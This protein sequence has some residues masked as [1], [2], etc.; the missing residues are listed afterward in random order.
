MTRSLTGRMAISTSPLEIFSLINSLNDLQIA[1]SRT[2]DIVSRTLM[3]NIATTG[4]GGG[5][6]S[7]SQGIEYNRN[8][9]QYDDEDE[10]LDSTYSISDSDE[11]L[12]YSD[13]YS[14]TRAEEDTE[15]E[16]ETEESEDDDG[17][18]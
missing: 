17:E 7:G 5:M 13:D 9:D 16:Y 15:S 14:D 11:D 3:S 4:G 6:R 2:F 8:E 1:V 18:Y 12:D 10:S